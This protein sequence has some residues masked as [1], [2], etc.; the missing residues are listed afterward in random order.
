MSDRRIRGVIGAL[1]LLFVVSMPS[2]AAA[3]EPTAEATFLYAMGA[4]ATGRVD[5]G[6]EGVAFEPPVGRSGEL[7]GIAARAATLRFVDVRV[8]YTLL[9]PDSD[10]PVQTPSEV[11]RSESLLELKPQNLGVAWGPSGLANLQQQTGSFDAAFTAQALNV[12]AATAS[13]DGPPPGWAD[14]DG[15]AEPRFLHGMVRALRLADGHI[16]ASGDLAIYLR[17]ATVFD[18]TGAHSL[19]AY[20]HVSQSGGPGVRFVTEHYRYAWLE[21]EDARVSAGTS[22]AVLFCRGVQATIDGSFTAYR[23]SGRLSF[24]EAALDF[25]RQELTLV[26][27][28]TLEE[29]LE[30]HDERQMSTRT[31]AKAE[32]RF[33]AVGLDFANVQSIDGPKWAT[34]AT[35]AAGGL[36]LAVIGVVVLYSRIAEDHVLDRPERRRLYE[37]ITA[38]PGIEFARLLEQ[39]PMSATN[40]RYHLKLLERRGL[41]RVVSVQGRHRYVPAGLDANRTRQALLLSEDPKLRGLLS[42]LNGDGLPASELVDALRR[43]WGLSRTGGWKVLDR[44]VRAHLVERLVMQRRVIVR[45]AP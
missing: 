12:G 43:D 40:A 34:V 23:A 1:L 33:D 42:H 45:R 38:N 20:R 18:A 39:N 22:G 14:A 19:P 2:M 25:D 5:G 27:R 35:A 36:V 7:A 13:A 11:H 8:N 3:E 32:G 21:L 16:E 24:G 4:R 6:C 28:F 44:A 29:S 30:A 37:T 17:E 9:L 41:V 31:Q 26:G 15:V 10:E